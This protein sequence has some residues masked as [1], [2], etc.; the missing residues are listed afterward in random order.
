MQFILKHI[1]SI[2]SEYK[3]HPPLSHF[4]KQYYRDHKK[5]GSRDRRAISEAVYLYYRIAAFVPSSSKVLDVVYS[6]IQKC[7]SQ[8]PLLQRIFNNEDFEKINLNFDKPN[9][10]AFSKGITKEA[11]FSS[12]MKQPKT[13]IRIRKNKKG[14]IDQL[15]DANIEFTEI[16]DSALALPNG[17][18]LSTLLPAED[19]VVQDLSSQQSLDA[20]FEVIEQNKKLS[21]WD[22]CSGAGGK[23][24]LLKDRLPNAEILC[25]DLRSTIL[26]NL[27][28]RARLYGHQKIKTQVLDASK[29]LPITEP[30]D[31]VMCDVPCSGSGTW[32][33]TPEQF[34]F[35]NEDKIAE[36][37]KMQLSIV[38]NAAKTVKANGYLLYITCSVFK[39]ENEGVV[40]K[41]IA[42][43][44][45]LHCLS[46]ETIDGR[47][48]G[49]DSMFAALL[50][51]K[52]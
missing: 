4:L 8:N 10:L 16:N 21:M 9:D 48:Y 1:E 12:M 44:P 32:A 2:I 31:I 5:L 23:T 3:G 50:Q 34:Y 33:R 42:E 15:I 46:E 35:F 26:H 25:T 38:R 7:N 36:F 39:K 47:N 20:L 49:A 45:Q 13:F 28:E 17:V 27:R 22:A 29:S 11:W 14:I 30:F 6:A 51:K 41:L 52:S 24:L 18:D 19:Y 37:Q 43:N 40:Q